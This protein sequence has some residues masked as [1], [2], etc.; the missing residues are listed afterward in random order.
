MKTSCT[1]WGK[2]AAAIMLNK[3]KDTLLNVVCKGKTAVANT[4]K[5][6]KYV[7]VIYFIVVLVLLLTYYAAWLYLFLEGKATL[8]DLLAI[9]QE[10]IST[11]MIGFITFIAGCF[12][13]LNKNSIPDQFEK[14]KAQNEAVFDNEEEKTPV[15]IGF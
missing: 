1:N 12:V 7:V 10:T 4:E 13:D 11:T 5:P 14:D 2:G 15:R 8:A 3:I 6:I 9:I